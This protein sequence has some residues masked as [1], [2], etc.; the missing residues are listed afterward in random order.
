MA[1]L[2]SGR[3]LSLTIDGLSYD[4]LGSSCVLAR[5]LN[6]SRVEAFGGP[7]YRTTTREGTLQVTLYTDWGDPASL[8]RAMEDAATAAPDTSL[9]FTFTHNGQ[10]FAGAVLPEHP[11]VGGEADELTE[12][13]LELTIDSGVPITLDG[14]PLPERGAAL[15]ERGA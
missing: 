3:D 12:V 11:D 6:R 1:D 8:L 9:P 7:R 4:A 5:T 2:Q 15:P 14:D 10:I 13:T